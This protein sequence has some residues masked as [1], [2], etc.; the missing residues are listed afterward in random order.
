MKNIH[1]LSITS[2]V[3]LSLYTSYM[4]YLDKYHPILI[5]TWLSSVILILLPGI[6][7]QKFPPSF[8]LRTFF[9]P[10]II[11][12]IPP[13]ILFLLFSPTRLHTDDTIL[14]YVSSTTDF[15]K[16]NFFSGFPQD[17]TVLISQFP[18][19]LYIIQ[20]FFLSIFGHTIMGIKISNLPYSFLVSLFLYK[21][22]RELFS[23]SIAIISVL[24]YGLF[25][26]SLYLETLGV[27]YISSFAVCPVFLYFSIRAIKAPR[28]T[29][30][31]RLGIVCGLCFLFYYSSYISIPLLFIVPLLTNSKSIQKKAVYL[32]LSL[33]GFITIILPFFT[34]AYK[35]ENLFTSRTSQV[36][37]V[38][39]SWSSHKD[40]KINLKERISLYVSN[41]KLSVKSL[42]QNNIGGAGGYNF[43]SL[44][45]LNPTSLALSIIGGLIILIKSIKSPGYSIIILSMS[46]SFTTMALAISPPGFHRFHI[47][48]P[49]FALT[50]SAA[51]SLITKP[52]HLVIKMASIFIGALLIGRYS[53]ENLSSFNRAARNEYNSQYVQLA[54]IINNQYLGRHIHVASF[55]GFVFERVYF[56]KSS[57]KVLSIDTR[58]HDDYLNNFN[59]NEKYI[60]VMTMPEVFKEKFEQADQNGK[61]VNFSQ[62]FGLFVN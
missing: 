7:S 13:T 52:R 33:T 48:Y 35:F 61:Y 60:Y 43:G 20:K 62:D 34:H 23:D 10:I 54:D 18:A 8:R 22:S 50:M 57:D 55:P 24:L 15:I 42:V 46:L 5:V 21:I 26:P 53:L 45:F 6:F 58:Y 56:F 31:L 16:S 44:S 19:P 47:S 25:F 28:Y 4:I 12:L 41:F 39:G 32:S 17:K 9:V 14:A 29:G 3:F 36:A 11:A 30:F 1:L 59:R 51:F 27:P 49:L 2:A 37:L 40:E 38:G